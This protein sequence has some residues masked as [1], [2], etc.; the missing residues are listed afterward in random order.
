MSRKL[1]F[2][3]GL[4]TCFSCSLNPSKVMRDA[5]SRSGDT[6]QS[7]VNHLKQFVRKT[8]LE[9]L[10]E[11]TLSYKVPQKVISELFESYDEFLALLGDED[12]RRVLENL[13]FT[14]A[15]T[16]PLFADVRKIGYRFQDGLTKLFYET[17]DIREL[18]IMYGV[19]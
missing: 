7:F 13:N 15:Q 19:F 10:G 14:D 1:I 16:N 8:P 17:P 9:V 18:T 12:K 3:A 6:V 5:E 4:L 2:A 11:A